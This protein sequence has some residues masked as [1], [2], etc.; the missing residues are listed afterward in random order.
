M[1]F[2]SLNLIE[3]TPKKKDTR[4]FSGDLMKNEGKMHVMKAEIF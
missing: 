3:S 1:I 4:K 2:L